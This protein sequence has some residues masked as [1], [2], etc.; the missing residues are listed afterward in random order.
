MLKEFYIEL[1]KKPKEAYRLIPIR[2]FSG[3]W[4][5]YYKFYYESNTSRKTEKNEA[6]YMSF[7]DFITIFELSCTWE[8]KIRGNFFFQ[9]LRKPSDIF[10]FVVDSKVVDRPKKRR[11]KTRWSRVLSKNGLPTDTQRS[12]KKIKIALK[13]VS[14]MS[15]GSRASKLEQ[16]I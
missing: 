1:T 8:R 2:D 3:G 4:I 9:I 15:K 12:R 11:M 5:F 6:N 16:R 13:R 10:P 14:T 7:A